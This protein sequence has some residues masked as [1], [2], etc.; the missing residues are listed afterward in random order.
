MSTTLRKSFVKPAKLSPGFRP[1]GMEITMRSA[2]PSRYLNSLGMIE[3]GRPS[4]SCSKKSAASATRVTILTI[5]KVPIGSHSL[6]RRYS[7]MVK[8]TNPP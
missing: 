5:G 7:K 3:N 1:M 8:V 4:P 2:I 6:G